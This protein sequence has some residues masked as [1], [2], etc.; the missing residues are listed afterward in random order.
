MNKFEEV[1][2]TLATEYIQYEMECN[3]GDHDN[4]KTRIL[5]EAELTDAA[6]R[7]LSTLAYRCDLFDDSEF[8][9]INTY[10]RIKVEDIYDKVY[11]IFELEH[12]SD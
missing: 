5:D 10:Y 8:K 12:S 3:V 1:I 9:P 7:E 11:K 6:Y 2:E 4:M